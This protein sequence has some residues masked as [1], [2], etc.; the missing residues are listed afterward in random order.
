MPE[1][2]PHSRPLSLSRRRFTLALT[3]LG[4]ACVTATL[5]LTAWAASWKKIDDEDGIAVFKQS[6]P[7][8]GL[9]AF[10]GTAMV[11]APMAKLMWVLADNKH[12]TDWVDRL[13]K[14]VV[15]EKKSDYDF[16]VYQHFGSPAIVS[17][18]DFV[19]R[20]RAHLRKD[21]STVLNIVSVK[22]PKAPKTVGVRGELKHSSYV[23]TPKGNKTHVEVTV[24]LDPK[25][26]LPSW[27]VNLVQ[28]SWPRK[29][30][31]GLRKQVKKPFVGKMALPPPR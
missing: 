2:S 3:S 31:L 23:L 6:V 30:L 25:G 16:I 29:T 7:G 11:N 9:H 13:K 8:S 17:D 18:R 27:I 12:R 15:L 28:K 4:A 20:A 22:H 5:P 26:S 19:Y 21:G 10:R 14:S 24:H 1:S